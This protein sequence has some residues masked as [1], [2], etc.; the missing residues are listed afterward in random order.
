MFFLY[1]VLLKPVC[2]WWCCQK[3]GKVHRD[4]PHLHYRSDPVLVY[5]H[6]KSLIF[7]PQGVSFQ[8]CALNRPSTQRTKIGK[9]RFLYQKYRPDTVTSVMWSAATNVHYTTGS[10]LHSKQTTR[11]QPI[12]PSCVYTYIRFNT[13]LGFW[14]SVDRSLSQSHISWVWSRDNIP[15]FLNFLFTQRNPWTVFGLNFKK[16][17]EI[18]YSWFV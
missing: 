6:I 14:S 11:S 10:S 15:C 3:F 2:N 17:S 9:L 12:P 1:C 18:K 13:E 4:R 7:E 5:Q 16:K 8:P